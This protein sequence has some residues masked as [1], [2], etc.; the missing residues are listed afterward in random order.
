MISEETCKELHERLLAERQQ[1]EGEI[2]NLSSSGIRADTFNADE[3]TDTVSQHPADAG[4]E[5]F[6]REKNMT[7]QR[8]LQASLQEVNE[9]LH[10]FDA[11]T[12][13]ICEEC[14]K[15]IPE[16][17]LVALPEATHCIECQSKLEQRRNA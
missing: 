9:A 5:L 14:G 16:K 13:G 3:M 6:E 12:Y 10:K 7:L 8:N 2:A 4:T 17:R 1:F 15:E 11:G